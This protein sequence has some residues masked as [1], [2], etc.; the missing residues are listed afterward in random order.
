MKKSWTSPSKSYFG[1]GFIQ[2]SFARSAAQ[3]KPPKSILIVTEG[4]NTE[5]LYLKTLAAHWSLHPHVT[6]IAPGGEGIPANLV[7]KALKVQKER[8]A[9]DKAGELA[10]NQ[11]AGFDGTWIVFDTEHAARQNRLEDGLK[12]A[13]KH[14]IRV[15]HSTPCF[16]F[17]LA[18]HYALQTPPMETCKQACAFFERVAKLKKSSYSKEKGAASG[19]INKLICLVPTAV[20]NAELLAAQQA[21]DIFPA[22]PST[23]VHSLVRSLHEALPDAMKK[24][25]V[26]S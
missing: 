18:L 17:W 22:N 16:E 19:L 14:D 9:A 8:D 7:S 3:T 2:D 23:S 4:Q 21:M 24:R 25:F 1:G 5:P 6:T 15:A 11:L 26:L 10:Y 13:E 12:L 20:R